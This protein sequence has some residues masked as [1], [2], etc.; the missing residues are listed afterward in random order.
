[1]PT[2]QTVP[3]LDRLVGGHPGAVR[4]VLAQAPTTT[5]AR[6]LVAAAIL[7]RDVDHL[8]RAADLAIGP[9][10]RQLVVLAR[11][12]L[13]GDTSLLD[14]LA[15]DHLADHPDHLLA[16]WISGRPVP[17][18]RPKE[19]PMSQLHTSTAHTPRRST[20]PSAARAVARWMASFLG[21]PIGGLVAVVLSGP[22][23]SPAAGITGGL[24]TGAV[25]GAVQAVAL[26]WER[27]DALTWVLATAVGLATGLTLGAWAVDFRTGL[28]DLVV[29]GL[30]S[31]FAVGAAQ[32]WTL[33][34]RTGPMAFLWPVYLA[35]A[36]A[37]GWAVTTS[38]GV[39]VEDQFTVFGAAG[40]LTATLM[41][42][43]LP[44]LLRA[45]LA[46]EKTS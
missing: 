9:R 20:P 16:A 40:A 25:L 4:E 22:V 46:A 12:H 8:T 29:Q 11:A 43:A 30:I 2:D 3:L 28:G 10:E 31:G 42:A 44:V 14:V 5:S 19:N 1:M 34:R 36:W 13:D 37:S 26:R 15:R 45:P 24:L 27:P 7:A 33:A 39:Q 17:R 41:T 23:D 38:V 6:V 18:T 21:F 32:T 35:V